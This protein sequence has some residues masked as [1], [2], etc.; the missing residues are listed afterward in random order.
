MEDILPLTPLQEGLLFQ[1]QLDAEGPDVYNVQIA[2]ELEGELR[3]ERLHAAADALLARHPNIRA[4]FRRRRNGRPAALVGKRVTARWAR[5]DLSHLSGAEQDAELARIRQTQ[6]RARFDPADPPLIR[7]LLLRRA[8]G[9]HVLVLTHHHIL[10]DGWSLPL[11]VRDLFRL[12]ASDGAPLP[13]AAAFRDYLD[14]LARQDTAAALGSWR[15]ALEGIEG[16]TRIAEAFGPAA[17]SEPEPAAAAEPRELTRDLPPD[18]TASI[19][20]LARER[21]VTLNTVLQAAWAIV[22]STLLDTRDA[23]FG[24]VVSGR[25]HGLPGAT[26]MVGLFVNTVPVRVRLDPAEHTADLLTRLRDEQAALLDHGHVGLAEIQRAAGVPELFD[27]LMAVEN[28]PVE[29]ADPA[30]DVPGLRARVLDSAD[31]THYPL[32]LAVVPP[33]P[34]AP[35]PRLRLRLGYRPDVLGGSRARLIAD[36]LH[37]VLASIPTFLHHPVARIPALPPAAVPGPD[38]R[39]AEPRSGTEERAAVHAGHEAAF[40]ELL[41]R[42]VADDPESVLVEDEDTVLTAAEADARANRLARVLLA[43]GAGPERVVALALPRSAELVVALLAVLKTG[44][45][46]LA[47]DPDYPDDRLGH[48]LADARPA[49]VLTAPEL[50][51]RVAALTDA[52]RVVPQD[53][54]TAAEIGAAPAGDV[55]DADRPAPL[56]PAGAAYLVYTSGSTGTPKGVVVSHA[57]VAKLVSTAVHRLGVGAH[58]RIAQ[59]GSPSFDVAFWEFT[60]GVLCGG[61]LVVVPPERRVPGPP[62]TDYLR[63]RRVTHAGLPPALLSALP[64]DAEPPPGMTVLA[65]TEAVPGALVRRFATDGRA[66]FNCYG[67]TETTVNATLQECRPEAAGDRVPIGRPDPGVRAYVLDSM[68]RP[69]PPGVP[70]ELY[71]G[72]AGLARG[73]H[74][75]P[76]LSAARFVADPFGARGARMYRTGDRVLWNTR[77]ELE[78]LGRTDDQVK[79]RG[80][81]VELGEIE[82]ALAAH[83]RVAASAAALHRDSAGGAALI[84]YATPRSGDAGDLDPRELRDHLAATLP[85]AMLPAAVVPL[86]AMPTLPNGKTDRARLPAPDLSAA[87][88]G[89]PPRNQVEELLCGLYREILEVG[90]A[91]IDDDFFALGGHSLLATRLVTRIRAVLGRDVA[92]RTVFDAPTPA[93]LARRLRPAG[94]RPPLRRAE[95]PRRPPLSHAQQRMWFLYRL[96]GPRPTYNIP[97]CARLRGPLDRTALADALADVVARHESL[98]TVFP[99]DDGVPYQRILDPEQARPELP[100]TD[101]DEERLPGLLAEAAA[102]GFE[103]EAEPPLRARLFRTGPHEH[104][105]LVLLHHIAADGA[106]ARPLLRDIGTAYA[107]RRG[108]RAPDW[109]PLPVQYADYGLHQRAVLGTADDPGSAAG[110]Q[111]RYWREALRGLPEELALPT[112][113]PRPAASSGRG[114]A[115][116]LQ[117][118]AELS[119]R[120]R[121]LA[122]EHD[123]TVFMVLQAALAALL[124]RLGAGTDI[125]IGSPVAGRDDAALDDL[126]GFFVNTLV[127]RTDTSGDP[128]FAD[129]LARVR[130]ANLAAYENSDIPFEHL[131]EIANPARSMSRHPLFQVMLAYQ[132]GAGPRLSMAG[133]ETTRE[134]VAAPGGKFDLALEFRDPGADGADG[135]PMRC[136]LDYS[137]DLFDGPTVR[138]IALRLER[139][140]ES[141]AADPAA[142]IG[143]LDLLAGEESARLA[144]DAAGPRLDVPAPATLPALFEAA[145]ADGP[146][147]PALVCEGERYTFAELNERANRLAHELIARGAGP[148]AVVA[149]LLPRSAQTLVTILAALKAGAAYLPIDPAYPDERIAHMLADAGPLLTVASPEQDERAAA[150]GAGRRLVLTPETG[151]ARPATDPTDA[152]RTA[153]L[154]PDHPA[155][156]VYTSGS[157]GRPKGVAVAHRSVANLFRSH[158]ETLHRPTRRRAGRDRLRVGHAWSFSFDAAWQPQL[159]LLDGHAVHI[160]TEDAM[161]DPALLVERIRA[162]RID[163]IEVTPSHLLQ[164]IRAG[165][166]EAGTHTPVTLGV[167]GEAVPA[168]LWRR[169]RDLEQRGTAAFNL[170]GP[171][172]ATVDAL[173]ARSGDHERPVVGA[174]TANTAAYV[175][176]ERLRPVPA[177]VVGELYLGGAGLARGYLHRRGLTADRFVA[178]PFGASGARMYRTGDLVRRMPDGAVDYVGRAD[179]QVKVRGFRV[180][181]GEIAAALSEHPGVAQAAVDTWEAAPGDRRLV[182][183]IIAEPDRRECPGADARPGEPGGTGAASDA[184]DAAGLRAHLSERLPDYMVPAAFVPL[185]SLPLTAHGKLDRAALPAPDPA[186][187]APPPG[188]EPRDA[189]EAVLCE[190]FAEVLGAPFAGADDDFFDLGGHS[191]LLVRLR[192]RIEAETGAAVRIAD[193]FANPTPAALAAHLASRG[194]RPGRTVAPGAS[195]EPGV[196]ALRASGDGPPLF[197][198]HPAGGLSLAFVGL[199]RHL[200]PEV[201][202]LGVDAP[203]PDTAGAP[204]LAGLA[205]VYAE[206]IRRACPHGPYRLAGWSFGGTLAQA[207][208]AELAD[209]GH[210]VELLALL[211]AYPAPW[212]ARRADAAPARPQEQRGEPDAA[213]L[214]AAVG[215]EHGDPDLIGTNRRWAERILSASAA[216]EPRRHPGDAL[217]FT[218]KDA[219]AGAAEIWAPYIGGRIEHH[220]VPAVHDDLLTAEGLAV[221]GPV[222]A[223]RL[224]AAPD[225]RA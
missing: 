53:P 78:F 146:E 3:P 33:P 6:R 200:G 136:T 26:D 142:P 159:W 165:L 22:L 117:L 25:P 24:T 184:V 48:M 23:V 37:S 134:P 119:T 130:E 137:A 191:M 187:L 213:A 27:T 30:A 21:G 42:R 138:N 113:R 76:G 50:A 160:V 195:G 43:R 183:Y 149:L 79:I 192:S 10:L 127:L 74:G 178:D 210:E 115:V 132:S 167:G 19:R 144:R 55:T 214:A 98:R 40:P 171:T 51:G 212:H 126:V 70:A 20:G 121:T 14:W 18:T 168:S 152:D 84:A 13:R 86:E 202:I 90:E 218:A 128:S 56:T 47:L 197:C 186:A 166:G 2:L 153:P 205:P 62:L 11:L 54:A 219:P 133:L 193:L 59:L 203:P 97:V 224:A 189:A 32:S 104:V 95:R 4:A 174:P 172:E 139:L 91:G 66:M 39:T 65:G 120:L 63:D 61:R 131:V 164:L 5:T 154:H 81:R 158:R 88:G 156:V 52:P 38:T 16:P 73:Y 109:A 96:D 221:I 148:E 114:G 122:R 83:P 77:G 150:L 72:G 211:D 85:T 177:G 157:T 15:A 198:L 188:R 201:P 17:A 123:T 180:E 8:P 194:T 129:L 145:V 49:C 102:R 100:L 82:A 225:P 68:L 12:Y 124:T 103:L 190:V 207:V 140:L 223:A 110:A 161:H 107:A 147:H 87:P 163:F 151:A 9:S 34:D 179:D 35:E 162:E 67:P 169:L 71:L 92:L 185:V 89:R 99:D 106:S 7:F 101:T 57:G 155:Y 196:V 176:D 36:S 31:A 28:Y 1:S 108:G 105:L 181:P 199:R 116:E 80:M 135:G 118:P 222:L 111:A 209:A 175:L 112:D 125:P 220:E 216:E 64:A 58:S 204:T 182:A 141:A 44:S 93:G 217:C 29:A 143:G 69:V 173:A 45:A 75:M 46:Y 208:A 206:R 94:G 215:A 60:M 41:G 170:Y